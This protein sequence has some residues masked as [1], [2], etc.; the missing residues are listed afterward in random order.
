[1]QFS[2]FFFN[3]R[4]QATC[5]DLMMIIRLYLHKEEILVRVRLYSVWAGLYFFGNALYKR[6]FTNG[7]SIFVQCKHQKQF[8]QFFNRFIL[9]PIRPCVCCIPFLNVNFFFF[10]HAPPSY[11]C[12]GGDARRWW[13][14]PMKMIVTK[15]YTR[16]FGK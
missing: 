10:V 5:L 1:M 3:Y 14:L 12:F 16:I 9:P 2:N 4:L 8:H 13:L 11:S 6:F 7:K 15:Y